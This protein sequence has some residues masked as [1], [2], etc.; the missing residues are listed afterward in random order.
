VTDGAQP[1]GVFVGAH[2]A[3]TAVVIGVLK[4]AANGPRVQELVDQVFGREP[5]ATLDVCRHRHRHAPRDPGDDSERLA[6]RHRIVVLVAEGGG[7]RA[8]RCG[9]NREAGLHHQ[10]GARDVPRVGEDQRS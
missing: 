3:G 9:N 10:P 5:I 4:V 2:E 8:A 7:D 6:H 1:F